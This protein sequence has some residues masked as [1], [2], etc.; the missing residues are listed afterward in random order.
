MS[1]ATRRSAL[2]GA[3]AGA[4]ALLLPGTALAQAGLDGDYGGVLDVGVAKL[5][6]RLVI[7]G[8]RVTLYS[9][10]QGNAAIP[11]TKVERKGDWLLA[12][13]AGIA[14]RFEGQLAGSVL[15][16]TFIQG[17]PLPL[18]LE[19]G[20]I[21]ADPADLGALLQGTMSPALLRQ[22]RTKLG[23][24][25]MAVGW[26]RGFAGPNLLMDGLR[27]A[28]RPDPVRRD[29]RWHIGSITKSFTAT[30]FARAVQAGVI[31]WDTTL[32]QRLKKV[33]RAYASLTAIELLS[34]HGGLPADIPLPELLALP[35]V[36]AD[37]R[38]SRRRYVKLALAQPPIAAPRT[39][40]AY[41]N[42][43][44]V[45][46]GAML[47]A[48]TLLSWEDLLRREVLNPLGLISAGFGP[49]GSSSVIDQPRGHGNGQPI[50][51][52]NPSAMGPAGRL[53]LAAEDLL[54]WLS[55]HRDKPLG[56]L[57][58]D[59]WQE[60]HT[61]RFGSRYALG[62]FAGPDGSLWHNGSNTAWYAEAGVDGR[63]GLVSIMCANDTALLNRQ[64]ALLPAIRRAAGVQG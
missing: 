10:D 35:R 20:V 41:S 11:A 61:P 63:S 37:P 48:A 60:L 51:L 62:W 6:L 42:I 5:R 34:H 52:D 12:D 9:L 46:A 27:A 7:A 57:S 26:Q 2:A 28:G 56:F 13:F 19:R 4:A 17:R 15:S 33:P 49:P 53:H 39:R 21:P 30:L 3:A 55:A 47:E 40:F 38:V 44:Y 16:G 32:A 43:G 23:T 1:Q 59:A 58:S 36:E 18:R 22:V 54:G 29:D 45:L 24:P 8:E 64:R 25:A 14:A 31:R 50:W